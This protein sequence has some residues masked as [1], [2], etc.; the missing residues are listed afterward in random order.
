MKLDMFFWVELLQ[1]LQAQKF[2][3]MSLKAILERS[4]FVPEFVSLGKIG[5]SDSVSSTFYLLLPVIHHE[6]QNTMSVDW[7]L[8]RRCLSSPIFRTQHDGGERIICDLKN[9]LVLADGIH[10]K[11]DVINSLVYAPCKDT[12][13]F[14]SDIVPEK[15]GYSPCKGSTNLIEHYIRTCVTAFFASFA[16][17]V[18]FKFARCSMTGYWISF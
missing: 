8:I 5:F 6:L 17:F 7:K 11:N 13:F 4:H 10:E 15:N 12:F 1:I 18:L 3:E 16:C 9:R 2:Q 14:I